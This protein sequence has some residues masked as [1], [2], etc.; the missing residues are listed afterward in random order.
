MEGKNK[1]MIAKTGENVRLGIVWGIVWYWGI[2]FG[3]VV[4]LR[5]GYCVYGYFNMSNGGN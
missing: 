1:K 2:D 5:Y 3:C 4:L